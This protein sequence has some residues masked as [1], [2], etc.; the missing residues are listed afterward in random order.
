MFGL[1]IHDGFYLCLAMAECGNHCKNV[2]FIEI[3][4]WNSSQIAS[5][6]QIPSHVFDEPL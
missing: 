2:E 1:A 6:K 5:F 3:E 4:N